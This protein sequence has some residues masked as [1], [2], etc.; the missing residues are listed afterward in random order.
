MKLLGIILGGAA[1]VLDP[2]ARD[3]NFS[4]NKELRI[5]SKQLKSLEVNLSF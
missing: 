3:S 5:I 4:T 1:M 2:E